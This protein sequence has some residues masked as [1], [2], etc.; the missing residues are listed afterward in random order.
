MEVQGDGQY[1]DANLY[2]GISECLILSK[3]ALLV[4]VTIKVT[5][6]DFNP[7]TSSAVDRIGFSAFAI[8]RSASNLP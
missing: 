8:I 5:F 7:A 6:L 4:D 3:N 2:S 1:Y